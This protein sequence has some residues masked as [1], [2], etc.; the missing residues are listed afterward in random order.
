MAGFFWMSSIYSALLILSSSWPAKQTRWAMQPGLCHHTRN[1]T[2]LQLFSSFHNELRNCNKFHAL[3][4]TIEYWQHQHFFRR[5]PTPKGKKRS[6]R[7]VWRAM[8]WSS[9]IALKRNE[10]SRRL[11][12]TNTMVFSPEDLKAYFQFIEKLIWP[13]LRIYL[14]IHWSTIV[15]IQTGWYIDKNEFKGTIDG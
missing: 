2:Q 7:E 3:K 9:S 11:L 12:Q 1:V 15:H 5:P 4:L 13:E 8:R 6:R 14:L 10:M